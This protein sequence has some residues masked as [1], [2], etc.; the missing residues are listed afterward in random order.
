MNLV[1][2]AVLAITVPTAPA[3]LNPPAGEEVKL[4]AHATGD[5]VYECDGSKWNLL[6]P[7]AKLFDES[8]NEV[9]S[10]F[11][12]PTWKW[13][14]GSE[15]VGK[16][17]ANAAP[18]ADS[19]PWLLVTVVDHKGDGMLNNITTIQRLQTKGGKPRATGCDTGHK[20]AQTRSPYTADYYFY[21]RRAR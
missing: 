13:S 9:G 17:I 7:D 19:I 12:G 1:I 4:H 16:A 11:K 18:D 6:E 20:N 21:A 2:F 15:V 14:D 3:N 5:Q 8:G 10:H